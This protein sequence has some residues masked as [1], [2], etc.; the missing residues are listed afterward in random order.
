[1]NDMHCYHST[2]QT[3]ILVVVADAARLYDKCVM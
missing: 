3:D 2:L 1:M